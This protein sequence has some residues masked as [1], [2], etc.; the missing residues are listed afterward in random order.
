MKKI[1]VV[2]M[3]A[4]MLTACGGT[5]TK[6]VQKPTLAC[7][8]G[9]VEYKLANTPVQFCYDKS[10]GDPVVKI[11]EAELG[12]GEVLTFG[13]SDNSKAPKIWI[14]SGDFRPKNAADNIAKF[15]TMN[16]AVADAQKLKQQ[17]N[18]ASGFDEKDISARKS[19][20]GGVRAIRADVKGKVNQII[21][22]IPGA[23]DGKNVV[24]SG[25]TELAEI[26]DDFTYDMV[27]M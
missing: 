24:I 27:L 20:V 2:T 10:W 21:Y 3:A 23:F 17:V 16:V 9:M 8:D 25:S 22:Y 1:L 6:V 26:I 19:D 15:N 7:S 12:T 4:V 14:A 11:L 18:E 13:S 5:K